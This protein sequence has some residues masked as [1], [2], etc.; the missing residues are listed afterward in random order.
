[1][2][3]E[4]N[5]HKLADVAV[6]VGLNLQ[7]GQK[8]LIWASLDMAPLVHKAVRAAYRAGATYVRVDWDDETVARIRFEEAADDSFHIISQSHYNEAYAHLKDANALLSL[9]SPNPALMDGIDPERVSVN[10]RAKMQ[11][12]K[13]IRELGDVYNWL[14]MS[15]PT[16]GWAH[17]IFP[18]LPVDEAV[19]RLWEMTFE[20]CRINHDNPVAIWL[21]HQTDLQAR[22]AYLTDKAYRALHYSA[23]GTDLTVGLAEQHVWLGG[24]AITRGGIEF[25]PNIPTEEVFTMPHRERVDGVVTATKPLIYGGALIDNFSLTFKDGHVVNV[26][27]ETGEKILQDLIKSDEGAACLG[28]AALLPHSS[29]ISQS[30]LIFYNT[31]YDENASCHLALGLAYRA[32]TKD[33]DSLSSDEFAARGGNTSIAHVDFMIGSDALNIDGITQDGSREP[34]MRAGEWAF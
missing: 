14:V 27:A 4:N 34:V 31:L 26:K 12:M 9:N 6:K 23:P 32:S 33:G 17:K 29:P 21:Q 8:L 30:G 28:E 19:E 3:F 15:P 13:P 25:L 5:L 18:T 7:P 1:M 10:Q 2:S 11:A 20:L 16:P 24:G 22:A